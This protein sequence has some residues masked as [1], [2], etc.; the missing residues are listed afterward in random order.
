MSSRRCHGTRPH[1]FHQ[2]M[3]IEDLYADFTIWPQPTSPF[4][5]FETHY[6]KMAGGT[7]KENATPA[8]ANTSGDSTNRKRQRQQDEDGQQEDVIRLAPKRRG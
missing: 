3:Q 5:T 6:R 2:S 1:R 4:L 7:E 8:T